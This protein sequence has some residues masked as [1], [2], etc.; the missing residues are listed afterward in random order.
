[1]ATGEKALEVRCS[2]LGCASLCCIGVGVGALVG[3]H[4][5]TN[6]S[7]GP[8]VAP[9]RELQTVAKSCVTH[10]WASSRGDP[11]YSGASRYDALFPMSPVSWTFHDA[12]KT[13][14]RGGPL[15]DG[16]RNIYL[17]HANGEGIVR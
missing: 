9:N 17:A 14:T 4:I 6:V 1:M 8:R 13:L 16:D 5:W 2:V 3:G 12:N 10:F 11:I 7:L 15:I